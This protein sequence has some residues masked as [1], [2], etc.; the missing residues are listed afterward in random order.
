MHIIIDREKTLH[1]FENRQNMAL[2]KDILHADFKEVG[3]S[4]Q[5]F[6]YDQILEMLSQEEKTDT[7]VHSQDYLITEL[8]PSTLMLHYKTAHQLPDG[9]LTNH[10]K[11]CS[12]WVKVAEKWQLL[13]HQGTPCADF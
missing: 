13:Y 4:G 3:K 12:I 6:D 10:A 7:Q 9:R 2:V 5:S 11:R 1:H 8:A